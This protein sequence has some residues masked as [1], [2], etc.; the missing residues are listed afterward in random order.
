[1]KIG[2]KDLI[3][4]G[5]TIGGVFGLIFGLFI[6]INKKIYI[7]K[8]FYQQLFDLNTFI[9]GCYQECYYMYI[10]YIIVNCLL[11]T[12]IGALIGFI[13]NKRTKK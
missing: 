7:F 11:F 3:L 8:W 10:V 12:L 5:A 1:M 2:N 13:I 4:R 9:T 6:I